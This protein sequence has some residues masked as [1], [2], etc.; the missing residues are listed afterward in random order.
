MTST[1]PRDVVDRLV[2]IFAERVDQYGM[3]NAEIRPMGTDR[4]EVRIPGQRI[5]SKLGSSSAARRSW[6]SERFW[7]RPQTPMIS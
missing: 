1:Q 3:T 5:R 2:T 6:S 7:T 4:V